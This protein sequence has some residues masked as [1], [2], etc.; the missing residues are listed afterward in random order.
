MLQSA[1]LVL[2]HSA[3][4]VRPPSVQRVCARARAW[5]VVYDCGAVSLHLTGSLWPQGEMRIAGGA[6]RGAMTSPCERFVWAS[7]RAC[8]R[9][10]ARATEQ[11]RRTVRVQRR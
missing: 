8:V 3:A 1:R 11:A 9:A 2:T 5:V 7:R 4:S 6:A 10:R